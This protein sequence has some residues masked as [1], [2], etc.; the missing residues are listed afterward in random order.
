[1]STEHCAARLMW[2]NLPML[3]KFDC[4]MQETSVDGSSVQESMDV[5]GQVVDMGVG[6]AWKK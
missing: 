2:M 4:Q 5:I 1:M 3:M 6:M